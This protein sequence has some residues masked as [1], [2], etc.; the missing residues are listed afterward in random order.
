MNNKNNNNKDLR[1]FLKASINLRFLVLS[2]TTV[3]L[4]WEATMYSY[5]SRKCCRALANPKMLSGVTVSCP[6]LPP[7][8]RG[9]TP[10]STE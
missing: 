2:F 8:A 5:T 10:N 1:I 4:F 9:S 3:E 7:C 6:P